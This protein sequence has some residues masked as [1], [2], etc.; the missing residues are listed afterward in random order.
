MKKRS[1]VEYSEKDFPLK[2]K[3]ILYNIDL[4]ANGYPESFIKSAGESNKINTQPRTQEN[5]KAYTSIPYVKGVS[6]RV[7]RILSRENIKAAFK[8]VRTLGN[9]FKKPKDRPNK[10]RLKGIVYKVTCRTCSFAYVGESKRSWKSRG[11]EHK[12]GT[13]E[14]I[15][16][17]MK[18]HEAIGHDIH[19]SYAEILETG[20]S[21]K[22]KRLFLESL[23][24]FLD[25]NTINERA[26][27]PRVYA[28]LVAPQGGNKQ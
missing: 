26:S 16:S 9:I 4:K 8:P 7:R 10:E 22:N 25:K 27:F 24:S 23:H 17:A 2:A 12:T 6:E 14:N 28:S 11:A 3:C 15:N 18:Q 13:N 20:V 21:G 1:Q 5:P 19:P